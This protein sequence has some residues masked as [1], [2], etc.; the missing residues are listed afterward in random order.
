MRLDLADGPF[1][2]VAE[3]WLRSLHDETIVDVAKLFRL[4]PGYYPTTL[5]ELRE[6]ELWRRQLSSRTGETRISTASTALLPVSHPSD[7]DW[8][9]TAHTAERLVEHAC[10]LAPTRATVLHLGTPSTFIAG[11][12]NQNSQAHVLVEANAA[13]VEPLAS[14]ASPPNSTTIC[15]DLA[16]GR[17][18]SSKHPVPFLIRPGTRTIR[19]SS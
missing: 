19:C 3:R 7:Y 15:L 18:R 1:R 10:M 17:C 9:F 2:A 12:K 4:S 5:L 14:V 8:R 11:T 6:A 16:E 13:V